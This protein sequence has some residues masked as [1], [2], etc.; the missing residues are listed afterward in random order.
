M[1]G[2]S[3]AV[4]GT[5]WPEF[6]GPRHLGDV[7][8]IATSSM[9]I[10]SELGPL[11]SGIFVDEHVSLTSQFQIMALIMGFSTIGL[12][13]ILMKTKPTTHGYFKLSSFLK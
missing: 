3:N 13:M 1:H 11:F 10:A 7:R 4:S 8:A 2:L 12:W 5:F 9:V 6:F